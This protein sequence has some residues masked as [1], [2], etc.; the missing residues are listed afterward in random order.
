MLDDFDRHD[1]RNTEFYLPA[2]RDFEKYVDSLL[3]EGQGRNL[4]DGWVPVRTAGLS[5]PAM[6]SLPWHACATVLTRPSCSKMAATSATT[7]RRHIGDTAT[8]MLRSGWRSMKPLDLASDAFSC[9]PPRS[10]GLLAQ[11]SSARV[12]SLKESTTRRSGMRGCA[13]IG[14]RSSRGLTLRPTGRA[15]VDLASVRRTPPRHL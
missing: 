11:S 15:V 8:V 9:T 7:L 6:L 13:N 12:A 4:R 14:S 10:T 3:D 2:R 1:P 5:P